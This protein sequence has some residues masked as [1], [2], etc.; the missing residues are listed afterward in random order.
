MKDIYV[1]DLATFEEQRMFDAFF[2]LLSKQTR[3]TKANKPYLSLI[4]CDKT[5]QIEARVW[6]PG[7]PR[8]AKDIQRG[9]LVKARG[10]VSKFDDRMQM[11]V[12]QIRRA[13][14]DEVDK[15]DLMPATTYDVDQLWR[16]LMGFVE[17]LTEPNLKLLL[18]TIL[19]NPELAQAYREA[20]AARQLHHAWLGGLLEHVV[21]LLGLADRVATH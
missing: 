10:C 19:S 6:E 11:K 15:A 1:S 20:P 3:S 5:G 16:D 13:T 21:S 9:D 7:D 18:T 12:D 17:S 4:L 2:L 8:I 14:A